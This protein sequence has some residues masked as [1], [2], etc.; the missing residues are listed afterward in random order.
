MSFQAQA[1]AAFAGI[2]ASY[3]EGVVTAI[4]NGVS[5]QGFNGSVMSTSMLTN[6]GDQ[7]STVQPFWC[8]ASK[9]DKPN[10]GE[11]MIIGGQRVTVAKAYID[12]IGALLKIEYVISRPVTAETLP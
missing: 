9:L 6:Y 4:R 3:P 12:A 5:V 10:D 7:G 11:T 2:M 1:R 8:D